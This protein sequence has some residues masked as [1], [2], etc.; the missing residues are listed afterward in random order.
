MGQLS[1]RT[2]LYFSWLLIDAASTNLRIL[3]NLNTE[4]LHCLSNLK[5][6]FRGPLVWTVLPILKL[7]NNKF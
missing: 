3:N 2:L 7:R 6:W 4:N 1:L 5:I